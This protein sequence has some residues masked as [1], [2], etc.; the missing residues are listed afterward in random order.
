MKGLILRHHLTLLHE[1]EAQDSGWQ[2]LLPGIGDLRAGGDQHPSSAR[3]AKQVPPPLTFCPSGLSVTQWGPPMLGGPP[4]VPSPL[5]QMLSSPDTPSFSHTLTEIILNQM[6][7][8]PCLGSATLIFKI[9]H[10]RHFLLLRLWDRVQVR[11]MNS[12]VQN[13]PHVCWRLKWMDFVFAS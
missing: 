6:S 12:R 10:H 7:G 8:H 9:N 2:S 3:W 5:F 1:L 13:P 4:A 11:K